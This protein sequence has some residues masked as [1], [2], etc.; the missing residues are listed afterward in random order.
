MF[1]IVPVQNSH[2]LQ[3]I[4][5]TGDQNGVRLQSTA[6]HAV[7]HMSIC[8]L[9]LVKEYRFLVLHLYPNE[10]SALI[11]LSYAR[12]YFSHVFHFSPILCVM[13]ADKKCV[14]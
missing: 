9:L 3:Y 6:D 11:I 10:S 2:F 1:S 8:R 13:S 4:R 5:Q 12:N 7:K 14:A